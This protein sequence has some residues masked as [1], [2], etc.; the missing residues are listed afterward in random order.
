MGL[1]Y[2]LLPIFAIKQDIK[3]EVLHPFFLIYISSSHGCFVLH[4]KFMLWARNSNPFP[5]RKPSN[6]IY[7]TIIFI[8]HIFLECLLLAAT[9]PVSGARALWGDGCNAVQGLVPRTTVGASDRP[10]P[11]IHCAQA[12]RGDNSPCHLLLL[13]TSRLH[14][15]SC[16][17]SPHL[18][19]IRTILAYLLHRSHTEQWQCPALLDL[20]L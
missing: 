7:A 18:L 17:S 2:L 4:Q 5:N 15:S 3:T 13:S 10:V 11:F 6:F 12:H 9:P 19:S 8:Q 16:K 14:S 20:R 1:Y